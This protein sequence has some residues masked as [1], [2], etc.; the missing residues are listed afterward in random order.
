MKYS[1]LITTDFTTDLMSTS[2]AVMVTVETLGVEY[3]QFRR[4]F[5][6]RDV[7]IRHRH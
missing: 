7:V 6:E 5:T 1:N 2:G 4:V 3:E